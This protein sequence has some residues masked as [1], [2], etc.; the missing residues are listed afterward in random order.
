[1]RA[2]Q[3]ISQ[4]S[5]L[6]ELRTKFLG[7]SLVVLEKCSSTNDVASNSALHGAPHG[8]TVVAEEQTAGRGR[9][10]RQ[11][12]SPKGGIW[13]TVVLRD[14][15]SVD[16]CN[17]LPLMGALAV[18]RTLESSLGVMA[19][20]RWPN[21]V[22][23]DGRKVAGVLVEAKS[24]GNELDYALLGI[25]INANFPIRTIKEVSQHSTSLLDI[26]GSPVNRESTISLILSE[27]EY[28]NDLVSSKH[29]DI[30]IGLIEQSECSLG[31]RIG[32]KLQRGEISGI[33]DGYESL[34]KVRIATPRGT[35][36]SIDTSSVISA[37]YR[38]P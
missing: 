15:L 22:V 9:L 35:V 11:W 1:M 34:T 4:E 17:S 12:L 24:K 8:L 26:V 13:F 14:A 28:L 25:G 2:T 33:F 23:A 19:R 20:V 30:V 27:I 29:S 10:G 6:R 36:E 32:I 21:D 18:A 37:E 16:V 38:D 3:Q 7:R 5:I 31:K